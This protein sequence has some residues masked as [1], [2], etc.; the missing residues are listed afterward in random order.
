MEALTDEKI[1]DFCKEQIQKES[2]ALL[3]VKSQVDEAYAQACRAILDCK[4][5]VIVTG[6]GKTGHI[7]KKIAATMASLGIPAFFINPYQLQ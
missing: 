6:L 5:R 1:I 7:G 4:G 3:R 2:D